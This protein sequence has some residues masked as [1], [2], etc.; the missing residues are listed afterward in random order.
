M[1]A[2]F[3]SY[4]FS[5]QRLARQV[6]DA[7]EHSNLKTW[8]ATEEPTAGEKLKPM[9][10]QAI[11][12]S[13]CVVVVLTAQANESA[14]VKMEIQHA[15]LLGRR[16][17]FV[18]FR[19]T[20]PGGKLPKETKQLVR[21]EAGSSLTQKAKRI[22]ARDV[23]SIYRARA[24]IVTMLNLKGGVGKTTLAANLFGCMHEKHGKSVLLI[25]FDP[26]HNLSQLITP[27]SV[28]SDH[29]KNDR[30]V[31]S[32]F[33]SSRLVGFS[34][35]PAENLFELNLEG[36]L[37]TP[38]QVALHLKPVRPGFPRFDLVLGGFHAIKYSLPSAYALQEKLRDRLERFLR[39]AQKSYD[40]IVIDVNPGSTAL[41]QL[42][43]EQ[44]THVLAPFRPDRYSNH[45]LRMLRDLVDKVYQP[46]FAPIITA[47]SNG[48]DRNRASDDWP[49]PNAQGLGNNYIKQRIGHSKLLQSQAGQTGL[50]GDF[51]N[52]L[53]YRNNTGGAR[54]IR[55]EIEAAAE[56]YLEVLLENKNA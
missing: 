9:L 34:S 10:Q 7:L 5:D 8:M 35:S 24:P 16:L 21:I 11:K 51:T 13:A 3:I 20:K 6:K 52:G 19:G 12:D 43:V 53:A 15:L 33:E 40:V 38:G 41:T 25:D 28:Y 48:G 1:Y 44:S 27:D 54:T 29:I 18:A 47:I 56:E 14:F 55:R 17:I 39:E 32:I 37:P 42:A 46:P 22:L 2:A 45:G 26:Q 23:G 31:M 30:T 36:E 50:S 4:A 49:P